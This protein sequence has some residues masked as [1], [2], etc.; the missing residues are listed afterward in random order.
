ME[1]STLLTEMTKLPHTP[2]NLGEKVNTWIV[3]RWGSGHIC[4]ICERFEASGRVTSWLQIGQGVVCNE[5][6]DWN[7][8][9][10]DADVAFANSPVG[11]RVSEAV[12][13][14][15]HL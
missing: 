6:R 9:I 13:R 5:C 14:I 8:Y 7:W 11:Y 12:S 15:A 1:R 3:R 4:E 10:F 2:S